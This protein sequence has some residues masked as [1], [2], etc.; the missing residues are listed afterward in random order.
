MNPQ[1]AVTEFDKGNQLLQEGKLEDAIAA[2]CHAI[3]LNPAN[4]WFHQQLGE[5]LA[6][7]GR[8]DEAVTAFRSAIELKP[9]FSWSYHHLGDALAQQHKWEE[10]A[11]AF[12]K[13]IELNPEHFGTYV[14]L[15]KSLA[16]QGQVD[17]AIAAYRRASDLNP[18]TDWIHHALANVLRQ[19]TQLDLAE[20]ITSYRHIIE[21]NPDNVESYHNLLQVQP[22]NSETWLQ[23]AQA[24]VRGEQIEEAIASY[25]RAIE[26][27]PISGEANHE[28]GVALA[29]Q[30][31]WEEAI[32]ACLRAV[33]LAPEL[34]EAYYL[35]GEVQAK[36]D[37]K[38]EAIS[39][40][41]HAGELLAKQGKIDEAI[42]AYEQVV[43]QSPSASDYFNLGML[44]LQ[45]HRVQ[46]GFSCYQKALELQP[47]QAED[48]SNLAILLIRQ[49]L[50]KDVIGCYDRAFNRNPSH[51]GA[52]HRLSIILAEQGLIDEAIACFQETPQ[53][54]PTISEV[55]QYIWKGLHQLG[56]LDETSLYC[57]TEIKLKA[58]ETYFRETSQYTIMAINSLAD[59]DKI[60]LEKSRFS[61]A[62]LEL[63]LRDDINLEELYINS[64][65]PNQKIHLAKQVE[66]KVWERLGHPDV[67]QGLNFQQ[68]MV[69]TGYIYSVCPVSGSVVRSNQS[70]SG[71]WG[72]FIIYRFFGVDVFYL[73]VTGWG[74]SKRSIYFPH[75]ELILNLRVQDWVASQTSQNIINTFKSYAVSCWVLFQSY[76]NGKQKK[77]T[78]A[79]YGYMTNIGHYFWNDMAGIQNLY[80]NGILHRVD[81]FLVG[82][83]EYF[84][85]AHIYPEIPTEKFIHTTESGINLFQNLLSNNYFCVRATDL[86][87]KEKLASR[88]HQAAIKRCSPA[89]LQEVEQA[90]QY[91]P[92]L[93]VCF[94]Q[95]SRVWISQVEGM[96]N[97]IKSLHSEFPNLG[98]VFGG[99]SPKENEQTTPWEASSLEAP[100]KICVEQVLALLPPYIKTYNAFG[101]PNYENIVLC[102][103]VDLYVAPMGSETAYVTIILNKPGVLHANTGWL[104]ETIEPLYVDARE[105]CVPPVLIAKEHIVD[106]DNSSHMV[107]NYDCDWQVIYNEVINIVNKLKQERFI[108]DPN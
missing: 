53:R 14:G 107:R 36:L 1:K 22:D 5:S 32:G 97:I 39:S 15:G 80:E 78:V 40:Y 70:F 82:H 25:R 100:I 88:V 92:L 91:F 90:K 3:D 59:S 105:N 86:L 67:L 11:D 10:A 74:G 16:K 57:Q 76:I 52:Y 13:G 45:Q 65:N 46:E 17:R 63:M 43:Q 42:S 101:R 81:K 29:R 34:A 77:E 44:L 51:A 83:Y 9:D 104:W 41:R 27:N 61:I 103:A 55:C 48:Y 21:L 99:W 93:W 50:F 18:D 58:T 108:G 54:Q 69:E 64:F 96:A 95:R 33:E 71:G 98:I 102:N 12:S 28:L 30:E 20:A 72:T 75:L 37:R 47:E 62:N 60:F 23:L 66:K 6:K 85:I 49:G 106:Q 35:L 8:W 56:P 19:R 87:V 24:L 79:I 68:S 2:Y 84:S 38:E 89:F 94:R 26:L 4:S 31:Q 73:I 7:L